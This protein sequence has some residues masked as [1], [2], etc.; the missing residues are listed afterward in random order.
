MI[1]YIS[2][3]E[4]L[5][6]SLSK[7]SGRGSRK[8]VKAREPKVLSETLLELATLTRPDHYQYTG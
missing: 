8:I 5:H 1:M 6:L 7:Y 2:S 4:F 3:K